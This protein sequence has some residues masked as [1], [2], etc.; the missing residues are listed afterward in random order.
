[1]KTTIP[2]RHRRWTTCHDNIMIC[3]ASFDIVH[4]N[5]YYGSLS[6]DLIVCGLPYSVCKACYHILSSVR[7]TFQTQAQYSVSM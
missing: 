4:V 5:D 1:M 7:E 2:Q 6:S 3:I